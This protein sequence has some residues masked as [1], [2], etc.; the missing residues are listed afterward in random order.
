M[1]QAPPILGPPRE[2]AIDLTIMTVI[3]M[4]LGVIGPYGSY[5]AS[6]TASRIAYWISNMWIGYFALSI[7]VRLAVRGVERFAVPIW[8]A[9]ALS[10]AIGALPLTLILDQISAW[11]WPSFHGHRGSMF[12]QY[13]QVVV[14]SEP[15][16]FGFYYLA[17]RRWSRPEMGPPPASRAPATG[18]APAPA[19]ESGHFLH[20]LSPRLGRDLLCLQMEDHY[21]RAHTQKGS[22][23]ILTPLKD[24]IAELGPLDGLRVHRSWWVAKSAVAAPVARGRNHYLRLTNGLEVPVSRASVAPLKAAGWL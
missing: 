13:V 11:F 7:T 6:G 5:Y 16:A 14:I 19:P 12:T 3:G 17:G 2:W 10:V 23:L 20:R 18:P 1:S 22:E 15:M 21:V 8:F 4:F 24:A 9:L